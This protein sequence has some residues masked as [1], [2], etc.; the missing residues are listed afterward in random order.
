M[1]QQ[2]PVDVAQLADMMAAL[3]NESRLRIVRLVLSAHP[4]GMVVGEIQEELEIPGSTLSHH[5]EKLRSEDLL[6][7]AREGTFLRYRVNTD[8]LQTL[9]GFLFAECCGRNKALAPDVILKRCAC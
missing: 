6:V 8:A 5:L 9:L 2:A 7:A 1:K 4:A 3:G